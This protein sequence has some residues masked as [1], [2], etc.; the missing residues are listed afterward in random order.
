MRV[1]HHQGM[2]LIETLVVLVVVS[3]MAGAAVLSLGSINDEP[4][5]HDELID[6]AQIIEHVCQQAMILQQPRA[7][8]FDSEGLFWS[9]VRAID[10]IPNNGATNGSDQAPKR[11]RVHRWDG[12][13][14][15][16]L[17]VEG[18]RVTAFDGQGPDA[19]TTPQIYCGSLGEQ[20][21]FELTLSAG[22]AVARLRM[23][24]V[25]AWLVEWLGRPA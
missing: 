1:S 20:S 5:P 3:L 21:A 15:L 16:S 10:S 9:P 25:G 14:S 4:S 7:L 18:L 2:S 24:A 19:S 22:S 6:V 8:G 11:H 12:P 17:R 13:V 23:P